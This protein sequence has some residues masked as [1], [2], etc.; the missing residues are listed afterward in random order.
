MAEVIPR[1]PVSVAPLIWQPGHWNWTGNSFVWIPGQYVDRTG[2]GGTWVSEMWERT[3]A[4][5]VWRPGHWL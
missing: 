4:G 3:A 2:I 5:W 1:P